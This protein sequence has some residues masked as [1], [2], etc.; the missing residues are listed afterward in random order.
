MK[1]PFRPRMLALAAALSAALSL[2]AFAA[3][4]QPLTAWPHIQSAIAKDP[5]LEARVAVALAD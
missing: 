4:V 5:K 1:T 2:P 3:P